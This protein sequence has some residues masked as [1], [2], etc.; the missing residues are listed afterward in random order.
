MPAGSLVLGTP[1]SSISSVKVT[2]WEED[3]GLLSWCGWQCLLV[4]LVFQLLEYEG[5]EIFLLIRAFS[6]CDFP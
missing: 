6:F 2:V 3:L 5:S 4:P 1:C